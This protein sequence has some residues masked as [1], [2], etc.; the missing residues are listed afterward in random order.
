M[1]ALA[2]ARVR[3]AFAG[4][5]RR[6]VLE[7]CPHCRGP[8]RVDEQ[9]LFSLTLS[10]GNTVG[11]RDDV[12]SLLPLLLERL[13]ASDELDPAIVLGMLAR[14]QWRTWLHAEQDALDGY[15]NAVWRWLLATYPP[16]VGSFLDAPTFL[17]SVAATGE[18]VGRYLDIWSSTSGSAAD[19]H[20]ADAVN[21]LDFAS[22]KSGAFDIWLRGDAVRD[23]LY[24]AF[25]RDHA[26]TWADD[27]ARA[28]DLLR[29]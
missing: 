14:E 27:F 8:V 24:R 16:Q 18:D 11:D 25:E 2:L 1:V 6:P 17:D 23:R 5:P 22:R 9:D 28:Y 10:L 12:K 19:R 7:G 15:L 13:V 3:R 29:T 20:L 4:Y 21:E 26:S